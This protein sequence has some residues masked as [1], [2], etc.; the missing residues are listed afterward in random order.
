M[1]KLV[2][3]GAW[4]AK[5]IRNVALQQIL[6]QCNAVWYRYQAL[7]RGAKKMTPSDFWAIADSKSFE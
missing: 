1:Q 5:M 4:R 2:E 7:I 6:L 3:S